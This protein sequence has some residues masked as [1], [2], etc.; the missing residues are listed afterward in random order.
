MGF[1]SWLAESYTLTYPFLC[2]TTEKGKTLVS[3]P[4]L[5]KTLTPLDETPMTS[6]NLNVPG[7]TLFHT[8][9]LGGCELNTLME[10]RFGP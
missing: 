6:S 10:D 3:P 1:S 5:A 8:V 4:P 9:S 7:K 2:W